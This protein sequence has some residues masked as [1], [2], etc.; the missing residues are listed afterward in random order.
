MDTTKTCFNFPLYDFG[1]VITFNKLYRSVVLWPVN[2]MVSFFTIF[3]NKQQDAC[4]CQI[5]WIHIK[6]IAQRKILLY[7]EHRFWKKME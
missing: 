2:A 4:R 7:E 3:P 1:H 5:Y 6:P